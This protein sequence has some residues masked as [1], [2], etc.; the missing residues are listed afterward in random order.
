MSKKSTTTSAQFITSLTILIDKMLVSYSA[1]QR[2]RSR[3]K[4]PV[5]SIGSSAALSSLLSVCPASIS[6]PLH[7]L[8]HA[9]LHVLV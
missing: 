4:Q 1:W 8:W 9:S 7:V 5:Q 2:C 6:L 3:A